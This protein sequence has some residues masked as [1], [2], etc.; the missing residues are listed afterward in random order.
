MQRT[1]EDIRNL[2]RLA[3]LAEL[4]EDHAL[5][6]RHHQDRIVELQGRLAKQAAQAGQHALSDHGGIASAL[7]QALYEFA[8]FHIRRG[9]LDK[10]EECLRQALSLAPTHVPR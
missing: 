8:A 5:A 10:A 9:D 3:T 6:S 2:G 1:L 4:H 7:A